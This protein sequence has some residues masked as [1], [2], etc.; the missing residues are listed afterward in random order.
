MRLDPESARSKG[1]GGQNISLGKRK[2]ISYLLLYN[3]TS[4]NLSVL[5]GLKQYTFTFLTLSIG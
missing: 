1:G 5:S 2:C 4:T 3:D